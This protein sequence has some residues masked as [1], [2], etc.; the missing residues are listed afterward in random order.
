MHKYDRPSSI[1]GPIVAGLRKEA[2]SSHRTDVGSGG[3]LADDEDDDSDDVEGGG[4][5][6]GSRV[7]EGTS[8]HIQGNEVQQYGL[9]LTQ[10]TDVWDHTRADPAK[11][12]NTPVKVCIIDTGYDSHHEDLP[13][14]SDVGVSLTGT[15]TGSGDPM[16][17][18]DGHGTHVAGVIGALGDN[19]IGIVGGKNEG[20]PMGLISIP[21]IPPSNV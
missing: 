5:K 12:I 20:R 14:S 17:D 19:G 13:K 18:G 21:P 11:Y 4:G 10:I 8:R 7:G 15:E 3:G 2:R 9:Y 6:G 1:G 16:T